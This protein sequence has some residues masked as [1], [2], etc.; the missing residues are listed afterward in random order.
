M[1]HNR[2]KTFRDRLH[3]I[4]SRTP[5]LVDEMRLLPMSH[6]ADPESNILWFITARGTDMADGGKEALHAVSDA[7]QG[8]HDGIHGI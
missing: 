2:V 7:S 6:D 1:N 8:L 3:D 5:Y 4:N